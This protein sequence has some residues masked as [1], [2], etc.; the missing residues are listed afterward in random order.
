LNAITD[1]SGV[2]VGQTTII[3]GEPGPLQVGTGP[4]R[5]GVT[6]VCPHPGNLFCEKV[7]AAV[8]VLNGFGKTIGLDQVRELGVLESP[9]LLTNTLN[10]W[11]CADFL[12]DW[13]LS[14]NPGI[15]IDTAGTVN[16]VVGECND[17][18]LN[19]IQGRHVG[20]H[21]VFQAL[22]SARTGSVAEGNVG[23]GTG[24]LCYRFKGGIGTA[25]RVLPKENG[26]FTV[27]VLLQSNFGA[28][29]QL[30]IRGQPVGQSFQDWP[31]PKESTRHS[32]QNNADHQ[33]REDRSAESGSCMMIVATD[34]PLSARQLGRLARRAPLGL[35]R[36]GFTANPGSGDYVIAFLTTSRKASADQIT[37]P[38]ARLVDENKT[39]GFLFQAVVES[40]EEA[41]LNALVAAQT[42]AGR[43]NHIAHA[44]PIDLV[45]HLLAD[46][47][48]L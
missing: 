2:L 5:T 9:I 1:V 7:A 12:L 44:L 4:V 24:T 30:T 13:M 6:A 10:V 40:T 27:G 15:G 38:L 20:Q 42:L 39:L 23:A 45:Q 18:W 31:Q 14:R 41:V 21:H 36:T 29:Q 11:R 8:H 25:S 33:N 17:S 35:A 19:D 26:A 48:E 34:A 43:D 37:Q 32:G 16:L 47:L 46:S 3:Q 28:R 22:D